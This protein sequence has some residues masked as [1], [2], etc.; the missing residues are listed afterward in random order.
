[1]AGR[2]S[3]T[4]PPGA[5]MRA[6]RKTMPKANLHT[7]GA[8]GGGVDAAGPARGVHL[9][10]YSLKKERHLVMVLYLRKKIIV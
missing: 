6:G 9:S 8:W 5:R 4:H 1:M 3:A 2:N 10:L 7:C